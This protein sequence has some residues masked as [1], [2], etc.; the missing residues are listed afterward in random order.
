MRGVLFL[1]DGGMTTMK[2]ALTAKSGPCK[3]SLTLYCIVTLYFYR[4]SDYIEYTLHVSSTTFHPIFSILKVNFTNSTYTPSMAP[5][6]APH[7]TKCK[8]PKLGH[9]RSGCPNVDPPKPEPPSNSVA[10]DVGIGFTDA[11]GS[12]SAPVGLVRERE[13]ETKPTIRNPRRLSAQP[14]LPAS[15]TPRAEPA[16]KNK[17]KGRQVESPVEEPQVT[18]NASAGPSTTA[19]IQGH[20]TPPRRAQP[21]VRSMS[22]E[23]R[24]MFIANLSVKSPATIYILPKTDMPTVTASAIAL[25]FHA[26][27]V[28]NNGAEDS[29]ALLILG[30]Q[31]LAAVKKL[32][33]KVESS[34]AREDK[35]GGGG[36]IEISDPEETRL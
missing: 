15:D 18:P 25:G 20:D 22:L 12:A 21:P 3:L 29:E 9:P 16:L 33:G 34:D 7:C 13:E 8:R 2:K 19:P 6:K 36:G 11:V 24:L 26:C 30:W 23:Q 4:S 5:R 27:A 14:Q 28:M 10:S 31:D 32:F 35:G 1:E 17:G